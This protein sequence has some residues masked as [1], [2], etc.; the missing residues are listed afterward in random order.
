MLNSNGVWQADVRVTP[1]DGTQPDASVTSQ[2][3]SFDMSGDVEIQVNAEPGESVG[4][5]IWVIIRYAAAITWDNDPGGKAT[6]RS[7]SKITPAGQTPWVDLHGGQSNP[8]SHS[9]SSSGHQKSDS[10]AVGARS[11]GNP[12]T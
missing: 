10:I 12:S 5:A 4:K 7:C 8:A 9:W 11:S 1:P 3:G 6:A 2:P